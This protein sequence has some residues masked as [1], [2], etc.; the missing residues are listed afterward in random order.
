MRLAPLLLLLFAIR[1]AA[2]ETPFDYP[3]TSGDAHFDTVL[4]KV[5]HQDT[6]SEGTKLAINDREHKVVFEQEISSDVARNAQWTHDSKFLVI[7][8]INGAGHQ[9]WH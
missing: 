3:V 9:P 5:A 7:T 6:K 1:T 4:T 8:G 2:G